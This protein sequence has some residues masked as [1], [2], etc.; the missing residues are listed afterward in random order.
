MI[1]VL[2]WRSSV[3]TIAESSGLAGPREWHEEAL[4]FEV[5]MAFSLLAAARSSAYN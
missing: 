3:M 5:C 1:L 2:W 4:L